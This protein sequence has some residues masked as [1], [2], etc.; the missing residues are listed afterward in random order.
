ML[1][2]ASQRAISSLAIWLVTDVR[3]EESH[4]PHEQAPL[5]LL[6]LQILCFKLSHSPVVAPRLGCLIHC[7][8]VTF[9]G[10]GVWSVTEADGRVLFLELDLPRHRAPSDLAYRLPA[11]LSLTSPLTTSLTSFRSAYRPVRIGVEDVRPDMHDLPTQGASRKRLGFDLLLPYDVLRL[12]RA[13]NVKRS[14][15]EAL[16]RDDQMSCLGSGFASSLLRD[17][18]IW[19]RRLKVAATVGRVIPRSV[20]WCH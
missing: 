3:T 7:I 16:I 11:P 15:V 12:I 13:A 2:K 19:I 4:Q 1:V 8:E 9:H 6:S 14:A 10:A 5:P 17:S 18:H 20:N